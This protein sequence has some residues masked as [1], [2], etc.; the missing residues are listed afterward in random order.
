M[1]PDHC[2]TAFRILLVEDHSESLNA[3]A[4]LLRSRGFEVHPAQ[5][6][7]EAMRLA[8]L[9]RCDLLITDIG[10][11]DR[12]GVQLLN[13]LRARHQPLPA[14]ALSGWTDQDLPPDT[15]LGDFTK[16]LRKPVDMPQLFAAVEQ[17]RG[18]QKSAR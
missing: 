12:S 1:I 6:A 18:G 17:L 11:P 13:E 14:I 10:L 16:W 4:R 9:I 5:T 8:E 7:A 2:E 3:L 15:P